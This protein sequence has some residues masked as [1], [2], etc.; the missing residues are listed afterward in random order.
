MRLDYCT[1]RPSP[2]NSCLLKSFNFSI[3]F[4]LRMC[5]TYYFEVQYHQYSSSL[6][7]TRDGKRHTSPTKVVFVSAVNLSRKRILTPIS[8]ISY[9]V[10]TLSRSLRSTHCCV[11]I[12]SYVVNLQP[13]TRLSTL[14]RSFFTHCRRSSMLNNIVGARTRMLCKMINR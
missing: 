8:R 6:R 5:N 9:Q 4:P 10:C 2:V 3:K 7:N 1:L 12:S 11:W 14:R 13:L